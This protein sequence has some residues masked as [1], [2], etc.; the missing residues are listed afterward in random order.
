MLH[1]I[2]ISALLVLITS[3]AYARGGGPSNNS[4][5]TA[6][7]SSFRPAKAATSSAT[8]KKNTG[9]SSKAGKKLEEGSYEYLLGTSGKLQSADHQQ[10][11]KQMENNLQKLK[12]EKQI[13]RV[14]R[15]NSC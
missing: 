14:K 1:M 9:N 11:L 8:I 7:S 13:N 6:T 5:L 10:Q 12:A 4:H 2:K 15:C 3:P